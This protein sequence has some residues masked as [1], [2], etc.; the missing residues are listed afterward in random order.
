MT[1]LIFSKSLSSHSQEMGQALEAAGV[2][3]RPIVWIT[4]SMGGLLVKH[5]LKE[6]LQG[7]TSPHDALEELDSGQVCLE[8]YHTLM[9]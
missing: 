8:S 2:G 9:V 4:H 7:T 5:M 6:D 1:F 3:E